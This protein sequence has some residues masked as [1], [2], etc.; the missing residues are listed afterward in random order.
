MVEPRLYNRLR[1]HDLHFGYR[2]RD[3]IARFVGYAL[4]SPLE[5]G[6]RERGPDTFDAAVLMRVLPRFH[7]PRAKLGAPL[8]SVLAWAI[9]PDHPDEAQG[10]IDKAVE[11][12]G[13]MGADALLQAAAGAGGFPT[14]LPRI[15]QKAA[16]MVYEVITIGFATFA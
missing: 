12:G 13:A 3:E 11:A 2:T 10:R 15:A 16:R 1:P 4:A 8:T 14:V 7:G 9:D 5:D 6:F